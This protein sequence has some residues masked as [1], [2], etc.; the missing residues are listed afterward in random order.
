MV[1]NAV[2]ARRHGGETFSTCHRTAV[3]SERLR[4]RA[5]AAG[6]NG[7]AEGRSGHG[8][9]GERAVGAVSGELDFILLPTPISS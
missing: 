7:R 9:A 2:G 4:R 6:A 3:V 1:A 5:G 8:R